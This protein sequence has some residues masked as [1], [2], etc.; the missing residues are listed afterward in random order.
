MLRAKVL[1]SGRLRGRVGSAGPAAADLAA[2]GLAAGRVSARLRLPAA[3]RAPAGRSP[4]SPAIRRPPRSSWP[5][6]CRRAPAAGDPFE[7]LSPEEAPLLATR[8]VTGRR[9]DEPLPP[10]ADAAGHHPRHQRPARAPRRRHGAVHHPRLR[11]SAA[12]RQPAAP[13]PVRARHRQ[14]RAA[15][16]RG[17]RGRRAARRRRRRDPAARPGAAARARPRAARA[18]ASTAPRWR[19]CTATASRATSGSWRACCCRRGFEHVSCSAELAPLIR[20]VPRAETAVVDAYLAAVIDDYRERVGDRS[21]AGALHLMTSAGGLVR[22]AEFRAKDSLLSG[23]G[24]RRRRR[25]GGRPARSGLTRIIAF[26]MGGTSTDVSRHDGELDYRFETRVGD[27]R[28][29]APALAIETVAA[30]GGSICSLAGGRLRVGPRSA[31]AQPGPA[32]YG[33]GGPLTLTDVNL[34]LGR[35]EPA[36]LQIPIVPAAAEAAAGRWP[37]SWPTSCRGRPRRRAPR[38]AARRLPADRQRDDG[39]GD[40]PRSPSARATTRPSYALVAFGGAGAA[41]RLRPRR[42]ARHRHLSGAGRRRPA[43]RLRPGRGA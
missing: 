17:G 21:A 27:A 30:G 28:L 6:I 43:E 35:L 5:R 2:G 16:R 42:A 24:R 12:D 34:L 3:W 20:I 19:C 36:R 41:A 11:R 32:C 37:A 18:R 1:S 26:D 22:A 38:A 8:L 29:L 25:G 14:A 10:A 9:L 13:R 40:P 33:A 23:P 15:V 31:G 4:S 39:R 7:L